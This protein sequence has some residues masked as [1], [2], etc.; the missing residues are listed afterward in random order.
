M[1]MHYNCNCNTYSTTITYNYNTRMLQDIHIKCYNI[2]NTTTYFPI[3]TQQRC[4]N[5]TLPCMNRVPKLII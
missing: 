2:I 1:H 3:N 4:I 5:Y